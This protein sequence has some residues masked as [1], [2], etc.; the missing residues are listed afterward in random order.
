R[1]LLHPHG[2]R[3]PTDEHYGWLF[4]DGGVS[5]YENRDVLPRAYVVFSA[6]FAPDVPS[7]MSAVLDPAHDPTR[8]VVLVGEP[9]FPATPTAL[10]MAAP[11]RWRIDEPERVVVEVD[12]PAPGY[13]VLS[14]TYSSG[15]EATVDGQPVAVLRA[16]A[17]FRSVPVPKGQHAVEFIY[18]PRPFTT[19]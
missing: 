2:T 7:A 15:W 4:D 1:Y 6:V 18:H 10:G 12:L 13:L 11:A 8:S 5:V 16:N 9:P 19:G 14:D 17:V 3:Q